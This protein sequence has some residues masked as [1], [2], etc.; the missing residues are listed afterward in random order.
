MGKLSSLS[1]GKKILFGAVLGLIL[2]ALPLTYILSQ[3]QQDTRSRASEGQVCSGQPADIVLVFDRS[4]SMNDDN[5]L[6]K[7][8]EAA[9]AFT[10]TTA[11]NSNNRLSLIPYASNNGTTVEEN[12]TNNFDA[13]KTKIAAIKTSSGTCTSCGIKKANEVIAAG[14]RSQYKNVVI[15]LT[16]GQANQVLTTSS[17]STVQANVAETEALNF[18]TQGNTQNNTVF[19]TIGLG[20]GVN[21]Q[22]LKKIA[23]DTGGKYYF[24]PTGN[25]L[26]QIYQE[27]SQIAGKG[28]I[29]GV[30]Y[31]DTDKNSIHGE[32]EQKLS[33]WQV[34]LEKTGSTVAVTKNTDE[35]GAYSFTGLCDGEYKASLVLQNGWAYTNPADGVIAVTI[36]QAGAK[37]DKDFGVSTAQP[38]TST[39]TPTPTTTPPPACG[40]KCTSDAQCQGAANGCTICNTTTETCQNSATPT[41]TPTASLTPTTTVSPTIP[42]SPQTFLRVQAQMPGIGTSAGDNPSPKTPNRIAQV[43]LYNLQNQKISEG[44]GS[45]QFNSSNTYIGN[46]ALGN[47]FAAGTYYA[48]V[49]FDNTLRSTVPGLHQV[50]IGQ[51]NEFP[52]VILTSGDL[53]QNNILDLRDYNIFISCFGNKTCNATY[54]KRS[55]LNDDGE[56]NGVDYNI[57]LRS[58]DIRRGSGATGA[59]QSRLTPTPYYTGAPTRTPT[60]TPSSTACNIGPAVKQALNPCQNGYQKM[61]YTCENGINGTVGDSTCRTETQLSQLVDTQCA[62]SANSGPLCQD[63]LILVVNTYNDMDKDGGGM[64]PGDAPIAG[65]SYTVTTPAGTVNGV[66]DTNGKGVVA[67][68]TLQQFPATGNIGQMTATITL[69]PGYTGENTVSYNVSATTHGWIDFPLSSNN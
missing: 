33:G 2:I 38:P 8:K 1:R 3:Q 51:T 50:T 60:P 55:D 36:T 37:T 20:T 18:V 6:A 21:E 59:G 62:S 17:N 5:K 13:I 23:S 9:T 4:P 24:S 61:F 14:K 57:L 22:F 10:T 63:R 11:Q 44:T 16:D 54:E 58:F 49:R 52:V 39:P 46:I 41:A 34:S 19:F 31:N 26:N 15:L 42:S 27:I 32:T 29:S 66:T 12:F 56:V 67:Q 30:V 35:N 40:V 53:D 28:I 68:A 25:D 48:R 64:E 69:P 7:A 47:S 45:A 65:V 43:E